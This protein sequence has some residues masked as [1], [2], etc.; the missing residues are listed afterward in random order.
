MRI[1][2][3]TMLKLILVLGKRPGRGQRDYGSFASFRDP[4]GNGWLLHEV[5]KLAPGR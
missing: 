3:V 4:D 1:N 5:K 2:V